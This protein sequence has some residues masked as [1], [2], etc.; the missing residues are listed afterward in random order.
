MNIKKIYNPVNSVIKD[1]TKKI[2]KNKNF[3]QKYN[4]IISKNKN[5]QRYNNKK[6]KNIEIEKKE[7]LKNILPELK[8]KI[9]HAYEEIMNIQI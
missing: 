7:I 5:Y 1:N 9:I 6:L 4:N 3:S 2:I 8:E